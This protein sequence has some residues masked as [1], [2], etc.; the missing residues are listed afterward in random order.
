MKYAKKRLSLLLAITLIACM[1]IPSAKPV[2]AAVLAKPTNLVWGTSPK[3]SVSCTL[4][5][6]TAYAF[7]EVYKD[8]ALHS[9]TNYI[10]RDTASSAT[11]FISKEINDSGTYKFR[12]K[13]SDGNPYTSS[14]S[15]H[16]WSEWS[17]WSNNYVYTKPTAI[18]DSPTVT[19][20][21]SP[22]T[23]IKW[24][25]VPHAGGF[26]YDLCKDGYSLVTYYYVTPNEMDQAS[27]EAKN[28]Y[29]FE[30]DMN[31]PGVYTLKIQALSADIE[32]YANSAWADTNFSYNTTT[33]SEK[34]DAKIPTVS[35]NAT[36]ED[37]TNAIT[38]VK[39]LNQ[40]DLAVALQ[41]DTAVSEK[42]RSLE[43]AHK[44]K[45]SVRVNHTIDPAVEKDIDTS[46]IEILG[47]AL[48]AD[49]NSQ[50][51]FSVAYP[52]EADRKQ[53]D[54][55]KYA[56][57]LQFSMNIKD[58]GTEKHT[59]DIPVRITMPI[60]SSISPSH[61][62]I[63]HYLQNGT[64]EEIRPYIHDGL[65]TFTIKEF[66]IFVFAEERVD[67]SKSTDN[68]SGSSNPQT[69]TQEMQSALNY[70]SVIYNVA[71]TSGISLKVLNTVKRDVNNQKLFATWYA[72]NSIN[73]KATVDL[74]W[75][76]DVYA[77]YGATTQFK[78]APTNITIKN[79]GAKPGDTLLVEY[80][81]HQTKSHQMLPCT[82]N[83][84]N[85]V[86][87][88]IPGLGDVSTISVVKVSVPK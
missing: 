17:D 25:Y 19:Q 45:N 69:A 71:G 53:I 31:E 75:I 32:T 65:A 1:V 10:I 48:N 85:E 58:D 9:S 64:V 76:Y 57:A 29:N 52:P 15:Q 23:V 8:D 16:V 2:Q 62:V 68:S 18:L 78:T 28:T 13:V 82:L 34:I 44:A 4:P 87:A 3:G 74:L 66:S 14:Q 11:F 30:S 7:L 27:Q 12:I 61:L 81:N 20:L 33:V 47:A 54:N 60:P 86:I 84:K 37:V 77:P 42:I 49:A 24:S 6:G 36:P 73:K 41:T 79:T 21:S 43:D 80:Y 70:G 88:T 39:G 63:L 35:G 51:E 55:N 5:S 38:E 67:N 83:D 46:K 56:N 59:L 40:S 72:Q 26:A 50:V 22:N